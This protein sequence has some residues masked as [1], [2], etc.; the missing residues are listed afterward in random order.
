MK[1]ALGQ[2]LAIGDIVL[3][4][5]SIASAG[6][7]DFNVCAIVGF[8]EHKIRLKS[9]DQTKKMNCFQLNKG[10]LTN[11]SRIVKT[12]FLNS[13]EMTVLILEEV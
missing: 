2:D 10:F 6:T 1:D 11:S 12:E 9:I 8:T 5:S 13:I 4:C 3:H 7:V